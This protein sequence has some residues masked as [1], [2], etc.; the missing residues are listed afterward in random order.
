[1]ANTPEWDRR[2]SNW[3]DAQNASKKKKEQAD[4]AGKEGKE[5]R[6]CIAGKRPE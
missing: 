4:K 3:V 6:Q 1:M 5:R 2:S